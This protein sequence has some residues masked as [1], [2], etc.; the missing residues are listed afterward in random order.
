MKGDRNGQEQDLW[1]Q[2]LEEMLFGGVDWGRARAAWVAS[3]WQD[4]VIAQM[5]F[6]LINLWASSALTAMAAF[7]SSGFHEDVAR[8]QINP[9]GVIL[10]AG[11][12][13]AL[14]WLGVK[15]A[16]EAWA[17]PRLALALSAQGCLL[18]ASSRWGWI[19]GGDLVAMGFWWRWV[20]PVA[21][22]TTALAATL[23]LAMDRWVDKPAQAW[24]SREWQAW[25]A[26]VGAASGQ[27]S[28][29]MDRR[30]NHAWATSHGSLGGMMRSARQEAASS[31]VVLRWIHWAV[32][33]G[34]LSAPSLMG[35]PVERLEELAGQW[36][37]Q[38]LASE[39]ERQEFGK[40]SATAPNA[41]REVVRL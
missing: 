25:R 6:L 39:R 15:E 37:P 23:R 33:R 21:L 29:A 20:A 8:G 36:M 17:G 35:R 1:R 9:L 30:D 38:A 14:L 34:L 31:A 12:A 4:G 5:G 24:L 18:C 11:L 13:C 7:A 22:G 19:H 27:G 41:R 26:H 10:A 28:Q 3:R 32:D 40:I 2:Q 16:R